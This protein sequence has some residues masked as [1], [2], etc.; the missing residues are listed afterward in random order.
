MKR[1]RFTEEQIVGIV[2]NGAHSSHIL[3]EIRS[4]DAPVRQIASLK[5]CNKRPLLLPNNYHGARNACGAE[6]GLSSS[7]ACCD[8]YSASG[9][10]V[11]LTIRIH[12]LISFG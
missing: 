11:E 4:A 9:K 5:Y 1:S 2:L 6:R 3:H 10:R 12:G 7:I 8:A